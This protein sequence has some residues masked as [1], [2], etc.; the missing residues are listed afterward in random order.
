MMRSAP[1]VLTTRTCRRR[2]TAVTARR[3]VSRRTGRVVLSS[4]PASSERFPEE[5]ASLH[6]L[7]DEVRAIWE[8]RLDPL[9]HQDLAAYRT[10]RRRHP[11]LRGESPRCQ[12]QLQGQRCRTRPCPPSVSNG[13]KPPLSGRSVRTPRLGA[14]VATELARCGISAR[15]RCERIG[16]AVV[17]AVSRHRNVRFR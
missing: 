3:A 14:V 12:V 13:E 5:T 11:E 15:S 6:G 1:H 16:G 7:A 4:N 8:E 17:G 10:H 9:R 2:G